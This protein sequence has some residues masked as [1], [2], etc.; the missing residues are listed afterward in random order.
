MDISTI[1][2]VKHAYFPKLIF[3]K[4]DCQ[5]LNETDKAP[6]GMTNKKNKYD[7]DKQECNG[8]F[9]SSR[10][11][12]WVSMVCPLQPLSPL[13]DLSVDGQVE[14]YQD[15]HGQDVEEQGHRSGGLQDYVS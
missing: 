6:H 1:L 2:K 12:Q 4:H 7:S 8:D 3:T 14:A 11:S 5:E 15:H 13:P 10:G 9:S